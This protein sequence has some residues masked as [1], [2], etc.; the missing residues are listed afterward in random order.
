MSMNADDLNQA[1]HCWTH[2]GV[3]GDRSCEELA[4]TTHCHNCEVYTTAGRD[5]LEREVP[6]D[7]LK[8]WTDAFAQPQATQSAP[9]AVLP[10]GQAVELFSALIFRL[11]H[12]Y[13]ALPVSALQEIT[14]P[15]PIHSLPHRRSPA[16]L[17]LVNIR[18]RIL[19]CASLNHLLGLNHRSSGSTLQKMLVVGHG[20]R[21]WVF[22]ADEVQRIYRFQGNEL[23]APP[24][25]VSYAS[26]TYTQGV[27]NWHGKKINYLDVELL[28]HSL[29]RKL[30]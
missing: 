18:G 26:D 12:E 8:E 24:V 13:F 7:Y 11:S 5:L 10:T 14:P 9:Q 19:L 27:I 22:L 29:D 21:T 28:L 25:V 23:K 6:L 3:S 20:D 2:I 30:L 15:M 4:T 17:G 16:L 1:H